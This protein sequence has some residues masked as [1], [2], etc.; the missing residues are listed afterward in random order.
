MAR[1]TAVD[2]AGR[3]RLERARADD[4]VRGYQ[5]RGYLFIEGCLF[6][7]AVTCIMSFLAMNEI[8]LEVMGIVGRDSDCILPSTHVEIAKDMRRVVIDDDDHST[9]LSELARR[10]FR[11]GLFKKFPETRHFVDA[12]FARVRSPENFALRTDYEGEFIS[13]VWLNLA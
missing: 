5:G 8:E 6:G 4:L 13:S 3:I 10:R 12:K 7:Y 1:E 2:G 11:S 9:R